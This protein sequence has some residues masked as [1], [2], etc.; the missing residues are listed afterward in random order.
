MSDP[1][2][3]IAADEIQ[4]DEEAILN[5]NGNGDEGTAMEEDPVLEM[6]KR[7]SEI[8]QEAQ[9]IRAMQ[10]EVEK[11][12]NMSGASVNNSGSSATHHHTPEEQAEIDARSVYVGNVDYYSRPEELEEHFHGCGSVERVT[13]LYDKFTGHP[14]G[15]AYI[16]FTDKE[17]MQNAL[18]MNETLFRGRQIKVTMKR[19]N[20]PGIS[21]TNRPPR[22]RGRARMVVKYIY[23]GFRGNRGRAPRR[24]GFAPY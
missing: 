12:M 23:G 16:E 24:R 9:M 5:G 11:Q 7:M 20:K 4:L 17:G 21:T 19:T 14:K 1:S 3:E 10:T 8:E 18:A 2:A 6:Q 22:G 15:F 13:I